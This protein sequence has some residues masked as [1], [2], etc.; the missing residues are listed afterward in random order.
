MTIQEI[1]ALMQLFSDSAIAELEVSDPESR[2]MLKKA[3]AAPAERGGVQIE[4]T[5]SNPAPAEMAAGQDSAAPETVPG[6]G[7]TALTDVKAPLAGVFYRAASPESPPYV[8]AGQ[9]VKKGDAIGLIEAM[10]VMNEITAPA[11][12][13]I[14]EIR[15]ENESFVSYDEVLM[16]IRPEE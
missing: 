11:D 6:A 14:A 1:K 10:K 8:M 13:V 4:K 3:V 5:N 16:Q 9:T 15:A 7:D 12:G 2:L